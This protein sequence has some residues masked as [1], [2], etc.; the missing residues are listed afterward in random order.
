M[1]ESE[2][3]DWEFA[4]ACVARSLD[5]YKDPELRVGMRS[6]MM[7]AAHLC[8]MIAADIKKQRR[9]SKERSA[10]IAL[11]T[12]CADAIEYM[13]RTVEVPRPDYQEFEATAIGLIATGEYIRAIKHHRTI[14]GS[15]LK[16]AKDAIDAL[17]AKQG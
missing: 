9:P 16:E 8:E 17:R 4:D 1:S 12:R 2:N 7:D 11:A 5:M 14:F 6:G 15:G 13:R 3:A 10:L